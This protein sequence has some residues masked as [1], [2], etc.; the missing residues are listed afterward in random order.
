[1]FQ[2]QISLFNYYPFSMTRRLELALN[3][4]RFGFRREVT[5]NFYTPEGLFI[6]QERERVDAPDAIYLAQLSLAYVL[7]TSIFGL[8]APLSGTRYRLEVGNTLGDLQ[9]FTALADYRT[10]YRLR[11]F[12]LGFRGYHMGRYGRDPDA[13]NPMFIGD[14]FLVRGASGLLSI[15]LRG[16]CWLI[17]CL[18]IKPS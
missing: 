5:H 14:P 6:D 3:G 4:I 17:I 10:Y 18:G 8:T 7:D 12:T 11:P 1:M 9:W 16:L 2:T 15:T 13:L